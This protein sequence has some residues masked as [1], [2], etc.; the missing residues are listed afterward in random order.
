VEDPLGQGPACHTRGVLFEEFSRR[1]RSSLAGVAEVADFG[2]VSEGQY[3][4]PLLSATSPGGD[5]ETGPWVLITAGF[6][7]DEKSGPLTLLEHAPAIV[8]YAR[9]RGVGLR[10][11]PCINPSGFEAH[12]RYNVSGE[13]PNNDFLHYEIAPGIWKGELR[14]GQSFVRCEPSLAA[15]KETLALRN[16]LGRY[17]VP[18]AALDLH[19]DNFIHGALFYAYSFGDRTGIRPLMARSGALVPIMRSSIVDSGYEPGTDVLADEEGIIECHDGSITDRYYRAGSRYV[20][21]IETTT[22]TPKDLADAINLIWIHGFIDLVAA[23]TP[24]A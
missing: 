3:T 23:K 18:A 24:L 15:A 21:A 8:A 11:Y 12:I 20:A 7:G 16:E 1:W 17:P 10:L 13:R 19:Q 14:T 2:S 5:G 4:Y 9:A 22:E 6:H